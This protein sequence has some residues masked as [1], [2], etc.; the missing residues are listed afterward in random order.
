MKRWTSFAAIA[1]AISLS[2]LTGC[3]DDPKETTKTDSSATADGGTSDTAADGS[4]STD[5]AVSDTGAGT[6]VAVTDTADVA[7]APDVIPGDIVAAAPTCDEYCDIAIKNCAA[8]NAQYKDK[9]ECMSYCSV[10]GKLP[11]GTKDDK[12]GNTLGCRIYHAGVAGKDAASAKDHC[13]HVG[14]S[15]GN[16][17]GT[18]CENYCHLTKSNC[19]DANKLYPAD[20]DCATACAKAPADGKL[21]ATGGD[22]VQCR[23]YHLGVAGT[24]A[25]AAKDHCSHG[26]VPNDVGGPCTTAAPAGPTCEGMC[27]AVQKACGDTGDNS[28]FANAA[29]CVTYCKVNGKIPAGAIGDTKGNTIGCRLYH[30]GVAGKD[31]ASAKDH[32]PHVGKSGGNTC[33]TWCEN[34]C[35]LTKVN[36]TVGNA[37][38]ASDTECGTKCASLTADGKANATAGD[39]VQCRIYHIGVAGTDAA[40]AKDHCS[41]GKV[42]NDVGGPCTNAAKTKT[43]TV[44]TK[45]FAFD[46]P[47]LLVAVGDKVNFTPG[48]SHNVVEVSEADW[49]ADKFVPKVGGFSTGAFGVAGTYDVKASMFY[50]CAPHAPGMKGKLVIK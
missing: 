49:N 45:G 11:A 5:A 31:A 30:A 8:D 41:H 3:G 21:D 2:A 39:D 50:M 12:G 36:C 35:H 47:D 48:G 29:A 7:V 9:A 37:I 25:A 22:S 6:D 38:Y 18:W 4:G 10:K 27:E 44:T 28:Q 16:T 24:D 19:T 14:K 33:G 46:P 17:C 32:C 20:A 42:P 1:C 13:P 26:K 34:Y 15:G 40:T 23:I 43:H